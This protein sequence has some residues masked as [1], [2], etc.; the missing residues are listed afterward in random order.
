MNTPTTL[1]LHGLRVVEFTH[2]VMGPTCGMV[3]ADL[4][5]EVIKVE[6]HGRGDGIRH[7]A[8]YY[9]RRGAY[10]AAVNRAKYALEHYPEA[11]ELERTLQ[12]LA[13]AYDQL[14][15]LDLAADTRRV[16]RQSF[17]D[18]AATATAEV[19]DPPRP[20]VVILKSLSIP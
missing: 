12:I 5:A 15:M 18:A 2:M 11:P 9:V 20:R 16:L 19:S 17:G 1:P 8:E 3:L 6:K 4:G 7:V 13:S 10:V 14:G